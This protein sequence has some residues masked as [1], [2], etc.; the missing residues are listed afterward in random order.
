ME[1]KEDDEYEEAL[2]KF[3]STEKFAET[4]PDSSDGLVTG[5]E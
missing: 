3:Q 4:L 1:W 5:T 2:A